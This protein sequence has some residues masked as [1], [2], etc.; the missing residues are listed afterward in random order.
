MNPGA[1]TLSRVPGAISPAE[2][3]KLKPIPCLLHI[4]APQTSYPPPLLR[5]GL[6]LSPPQAPLSCLLHQDTLC[7]LHSDLFSCLPPVLR[8][9]SGHLPSLLR[10]IDG[11][12]MGL[13]PFNQEFL[14]DQKDFAHPGPQRLVQPGP[15][16]VLLKHPLSPSGRSS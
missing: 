5:L 6:G 13:P 1:D 12:V 2:G 16:Q 8:P 3:P 11:Q 4:P 9:C 15:E 7:T 14:K 10:C